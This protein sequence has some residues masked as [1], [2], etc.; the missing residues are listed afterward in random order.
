MPLPHSGGATNASANA[1]IP[2]G[3]CLVCADAHVIAGKWI[4][5]LLAQFLPLML[6]ALRQLTVFRSH[7]LIRLG[8]SCNL[9]ETS[10]EN[11]DVA[12]SAVRLGQ[13]RT[14]SVPVGATALLASSLPNRKLLLFSWWLVSTRTT[15]ISHFQILESKHHWPS[16]VLTYLI[17]CCNLNWT[18]LLDFPLSR[19]WLCNTP[20]LG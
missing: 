17:L 1:T 6:P 16:P 10:K 18:S 11:P 8:T 9:A 15:M 13:P 20:G 3:L 14:N 19:Q 12:G 4:T 2:G 7:E 5:Q